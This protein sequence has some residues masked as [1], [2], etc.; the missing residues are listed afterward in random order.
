M[1]LGHELATKESQRINHQNADR[2]WMLFCHRLLKTETRSFF[3]R[4]VEHIE[5]EVRDFCNVLG[6]QTVVCQRES[7]NYLLI[8]GNRDSSD[9]VHLV[10]SPDRQV[11]TIEREEI[12][13]LSVDMRRSKSEVRLTVE[14]LDGQTFVTSD[15]G[16]A[17]SLSRAILLPL[18]SGNKSN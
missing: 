15:V 18:L 6:K 11:I 12:D 4:L 16:N 2:E 8:R 13:H 3:D 9:R 17:E 10:L 7:E 5:S 14:L 1:G